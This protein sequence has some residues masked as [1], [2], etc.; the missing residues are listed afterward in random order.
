M[1]GVGRTFGT[2]GGGPAVGGRVEATASALSVALIDGDLEIAARQRDVGGVGQTTAWLVSGAA[3]FELLAAR[4]RWRA[5]AGLGARVGLVRESGASADLAHIMATTF[6]R[7]WGGPMVC[8]RL[9]AAVGRVGLTVSGEAGWSLSSIDE[10]AAGA[11]AISVG[12]PWLA[13][14]IGA[15]V[16]VR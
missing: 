8:A 10:T 15:D 14:S 5:A 1:A 13:L 16:R 9:S 11:T 2:S 6:V 4:H 3:A 12:G 7:P